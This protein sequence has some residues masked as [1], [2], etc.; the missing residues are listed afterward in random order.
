MRTSFC[1][2]EREREGEN[3]LYAYGMA[4]VISIAMSSR[5]VMIN[6]SCLCMCIYSINPIVK[7]G[8]FFPPLTSLA[9]VRTVIRQI[10][11]RGGGIQ[12]R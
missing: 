2:N 6:L 3:D 9:E 10:I 7:V 12:K 5:E 8:P 4:F 1:R 11:R